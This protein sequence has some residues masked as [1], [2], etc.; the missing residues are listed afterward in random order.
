MIATADQKYQL[1]APHESYTMCQVSAIHKKS[2]SVSH[3]SPTDRWD[4]PLKSLQ[5]PAKK[6]HLHPQKQSSSPSSLQNQTK[7][8]N[9]LLWQ[10]LPEVP[11]TTWPNSTPLPAA[12]QCSLHTDLCTPSTQL[13]PSGEFPLPTKMDFLKRGIQFLLF[14]IISFAA[15]SFPILRT[16]SSSLVCYLLIS[17]EIN[18]YTFFVIV[19]EKKKF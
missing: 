4:H 15:K 17:L 1:T 2:R 19:G 5:L 7:T 6:N 11:I 10:T 16:T 18:I 8:K 3:P 12:I 14:A 9:S 13:H